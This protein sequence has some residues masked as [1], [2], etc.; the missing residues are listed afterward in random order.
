VG[1]HNIRNALA[2]LAVCHALGIEYSDLVGGLKTLSGLAHRCEMILEHQHV[3]YVNDSKGTNVGA[4]IAALEGLSKGKN[5]I[6]IAGG[7][8][9]G[10]SFK[11]LSKAI[12]LSCKHTI[13]I[14]R[15]A[16]KIEATLEPHVSRERAGSMTEAVQRAVDCASEGDVVLLS[17]ACASF[18]MFKDYQDRGTAFRDAVSLIVQ[19]AE[20]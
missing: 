19:E 14:G 1:D 12:A 3:R 13:L 17:P 8:G 16:D 7:E 20:L 10:Q 4:S 6:L 18:D 5:V 9:K 15:D 11:P 2:A